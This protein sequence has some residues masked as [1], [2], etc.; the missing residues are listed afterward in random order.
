M[1]IFSGSQIYEADKFTIKKQNI[2]SDVLMERAS[3]Q[4]FQWLHSRMQGA[5]V[6][7]HLFCGIGNNGGDGIALARHLWEHGYNFD[8]Y[9]LNYSEKR[10]KDFL[11]NLDR[12]K[13][14]KLWP[15]FLNETSKMP[16]IHP[17]DIII[18]AIFGI[19]L[20]RPPA[21][22]IAK[23]IKYLNQNGAFIVSI[24]VPSGLY[25]DRAVEDK[26]A[27]IRGNFILSFQAPK[28]IFFLPETGPFIR[29]W[30][31]LD[32]GLDAEYLETTAVDF[33]L[34]EKPEIMPWYKGR[35]KFSHKGDFGH[36]MI[37]GGSY[38]KI[39]AV[40]LAARACLRTG[41]G[42]V[43]SF[44]PGCG[45]TAMQTALPEA[46]TE[47]DPGDTILTQIKPVTK[48]DVVAIGMGLGTDDETAK[49]FAAFLKSYE[50]ALIV[51]ADGIN[52]LA[53]KK[54][55][56]K[57]LG[58]DAILTPHPGEL[59]RLLGE[60]QDDFEKVEKAKAFSIE[61]KCILVVK[62][63]HTIVFY[64][65]QGFIN[66]TGNPGMAT[67][68][69]GDALSGIITGLVS[70][71]YMPIHAAI[72]GVYLHGLAGDIATSTLGFEAMTSGD[73]IANIGNAFLDLFKQ[74]DLPPEPEE[75]QKPPN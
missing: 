9:V 22:W 46:M 2:S 19:G 51:D 23:I 11:L 10:S 55:L 61:H 47:T 60:W 63:A 74:P 57:H 32:I 24:D 53:K 25:M 75:E 41:A 50:G 39:G 15:N 33:H 44:I 70:Q 36:A 43:S 5:Q 7:I 40:I 54:S 20:N 8:V 64:E 1:K 52:L 26:E 28:L 34:M 3:M 16:E 69:S 30:D 21:P 71:G 68:G 29:E 58:Q 6:K 27:V 72:F 62:G 31:I 59:L 48:S 38:G 12:L 13:E 49:A 17:D 45:Y 66:N 65:G 18:D 4:L 56:L 35:P 14:R 37:I 73:L 67:A 42:L